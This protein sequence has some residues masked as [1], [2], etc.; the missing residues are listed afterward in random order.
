MP[1]SA[2]GRW[3][4]REQPDGRFMAAGRP[5][6]A[7]GAQGDRTPGQPHPQTVTRRTIGKH[8][9]QAKS[10][11]APLT[12]HFLDRVTDTA[13]VTACIVENQRL[14]S[15]AKIGNKSVSADEGEAK[16]ALF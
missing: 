3:F 4:P 7:P 15:R 14:K 6:S 11:K 10:R 8:L 16:K 12:G 5:Y 13:F 1:S 9:H 2:P